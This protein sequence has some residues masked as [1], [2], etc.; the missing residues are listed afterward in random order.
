MA[1][2]ACLG[3]AMM[4]PR[5]PIKWAALLTRSLSLV[6]TFSQCMHR[7][8]LPTNTVSIVLVSDTNQDVF[9]VISGGMRC[10]IGWKAQLDSH[11]IFDLYLRASKVK[12]WKWG[13]RIKLT[14]S[15]Q[16]TASQLFTRSVLLKRLK[17]RKLK[18]YMERCAKCIHLNA[19]FQ[20][21]DV[22]KYSVTCV[23]LQPLVFYKVRNNFV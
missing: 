3:L 15:A 4:Y 5:T 2:S 20:C 23:R 19:R 18:K 13:G 1:K 22:W 6:Q 7:E 16:P 17:C 12:T 10:L 21:S 14:H 9:C 11:L 8:H